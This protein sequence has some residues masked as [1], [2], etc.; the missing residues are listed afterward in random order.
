M[1]WSLA[2]VAL[3]P[4]GATGHVDESE[5]SRVVAWAQQAGFGGIEVSPQWLNIDD[6]PPSDLERFRLTAEKAGIVI[7]GINVNRCLFTRGLQ[8]ED[9]LARMYRAIDSAT[10]LGTNLI[11][12][13]LSLPLDGRRSLVRGSDFSAEE[14]NKAVANLAELAAKGAE[15]GMQISLEL[16]DDGLLDTPERCLEFLRRVDAGNVGL[17]PDLGNLI[18]SNPPPVDWEGAL[19][20]LA[21]R[22][23][24]WHVK[25]YRGTAPAPLGEG[26]I[27]Y[28]RAFSIMQSE[29]YQGWVSIESYFGDAFDLQQRS[30]RYLQQL[31]ARPAETFEESAA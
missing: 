20:M 13:S 11:T 19:R 27:D 5:Q 1:R 28:A 9:S 25:N 16:H 3:L 8:A 17:N 15:K 31:A 14:Y 26:D 12:F 10:L 4:R 6:A 22:A 21:P 18:R 23:N 24:N 2:T 30:L 7:S 29:N